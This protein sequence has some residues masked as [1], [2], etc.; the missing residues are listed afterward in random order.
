MDNQALFQSNLWGEHFRRIIDEELAK[1]RYP[2]TMSHVMGSRRRSPARVGA[3]RRV[4]VY[5]LWAERKWSFSLIARR[6]GM[7]HSTVIYHVRQMI[8]AGGLPEPVPQHV[9]DYGRKY[10]L[11]VE[12]ANY[13]NG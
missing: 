12:G 8:L 1:S 10:G 2:L 3:V 6:I 7:D 9:L 4:I 13:D 5:R 11:L